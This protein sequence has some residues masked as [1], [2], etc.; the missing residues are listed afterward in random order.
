MESFSTRVAGADWRE[1]EDFFDV[2]RLV[3]ALEW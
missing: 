3:M 2:V 1:R